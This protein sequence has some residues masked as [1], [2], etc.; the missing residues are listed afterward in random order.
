MPRVASG[1]VL[2]LFALSAACGGQHAAPPLSGQSEAE[3][4]IEF[5]ALC[6]GMRDGNNP[7]YGTAALREHED[8]IA[9]PVGSA[10]AQA[11]ARGRLGAELLREG[12]SVEAAGRLDEA[13]A[14]ARDARLDAPTLFYIIVIHILFWLNLKFFTKVSNFLFPI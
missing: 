9:Q 3:I 8:W 4:A 10:L 5:A 6:R 13:L 12:R 11:L 2:V 7:Y 1:L 14:I